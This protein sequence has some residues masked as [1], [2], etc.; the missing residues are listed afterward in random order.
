[1]RPLI[2]IDNVKRCKILRRLNRF[3]V[4]IEIRDVI[5]RAYINNTGRLTELLTT[6]REGFCLRLDDRKK[7]DYRLFAISE[8]GNGAIIDT[9]LQMKA[10]ERAFHL[11]LIPWMK[12]WKFI[13]RNARLKNSI[14]DYLFEWRNAL[15]YLE[16]KS[17]VLREGNYAMYPDCPSIRGQRHIRELMEHVAEGGH[18]AIVFIAA[19]PRVKAFKPYE[20]GDP[21]I[22]KLL[23][24]ARDKGVVIKSIGMFYN[25]KDSSIYLENSNLKIALEDF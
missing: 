2:S 14:I 9:N 4:E 5:K 20:R 11:N 8:N 23:I 15:L 22:K 18:G 12:E 25:S 16:V 17:A 6:G 24:E 13:Q 21:V 7:T 10:F 1:M 3:V 19:L